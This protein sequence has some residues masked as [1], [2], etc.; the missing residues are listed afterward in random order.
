[1]TKKQAVER[2]EFLMEA[3]KS[4]FCPLTG[5]DC[6]LN[7]MCCVPP[8]L[9]CQSIEM[10]NE[11]LKDISDLNVWYVSDGYC[12]AYILNGPQKGGK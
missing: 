5:T 1:M 7:C 3:M 6:N 2:K 9:G 8:S 10:P 11:D 4:T 12:D